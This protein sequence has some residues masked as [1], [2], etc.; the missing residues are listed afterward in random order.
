MG[1]AMTHGLLKQSQLRWSPNM[2]NAIVLTTLV[3]S[4]CTTATPTQTAT[5][6]K[7]VTPTQEQPAP[8]ATIAPASVAPA[9]DGLRDLGAMTL[10]CP[11]ASL[12]AAAREAAKAPT[13]GHYQFSFFKIVSD[14]HH[15][16]Y[17][18]HFKSNYHGE[19]DLK[20]CVSIYCQQGWDPKT[21]KTTVS[22]IGDGPRAAGAS[23]MAAAHGADCSDPRTRT[24]HRSKR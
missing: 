11:K 12:N 5:T 23:A 13:Q 21:S 8:P 20:Y 3:L 24:K 7:T 15:G 17:E 18:V 19:P 1:I 22:K 2:R 9:D 6:E 16:T 10:G 4:A 14:S